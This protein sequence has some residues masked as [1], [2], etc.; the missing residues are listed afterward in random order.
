MS[1]Y[2]QAINTQHRLD[3]FAAIQEPIK[4]IKKIWLY[5]LLSFDVF[6]LIWASH[7][8]IKEL[9]KLLSCIS[10]EALE[11]SGIAIRDDCSRIANKLFKI[12]NSEYL[13]DWMK[14][15]IH[16]IYIEWSDIE[17]DISIALDNEVQD[18]FAALDKT[19]EK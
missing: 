1:V 10:D 11:E 6:N 8:A 3:A 7:W 19:L 16:D 4:Y 2:V 9:R 13:P 18:L 5:C 14:K 15:R 17:D 12:C